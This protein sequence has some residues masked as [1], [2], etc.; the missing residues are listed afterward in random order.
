MGLF[1]KKE[2]IPELPPAPTMPEI[3]NLPSPGNQI[4]DL[5]PAPNLP[6]QSPTKPLAEPAPELAS[7]P[8]IP[9]I[10]VKAPEQ[11]A[12]AEPIIQRSIQEQSTP[13][14]SQQIEDQGPKPGKRAKPFETIFVRIDHFQSAKKRF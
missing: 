3:P 8:E 4:P 10:P 1:S 12:R 7:P 14:P 13:E 5:P 2:E 6:D 11:F 9:S